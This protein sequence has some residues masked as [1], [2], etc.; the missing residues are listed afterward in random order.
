[1][2]AKTKNIL[3]G[4]A[5]G[6]IGLH[7]YRKNTEKT[8]DQPVSGTRRLG[9]VAMNGGSV[10]GLRGLGNTT[11]GDATSV[12]VGTQHTVSALPSRGYTFLGWKTN[13]SDSRYVSTS[14]DYTFTMPA[15]DMTL[16]AYFASQSYK[17]DTHPV[18]DDG[19]QVR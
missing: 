13:P 4:V 1:M 10:R 2:K 7:L 12:R 14:L 5:A 11:S 16:Y 15:N 8:A 6:A 17:V 9:V 3:M 18:V 19:A